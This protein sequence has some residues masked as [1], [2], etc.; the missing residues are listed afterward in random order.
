MAVPSV[1]LLP[2]CAAYGPRLTDALERAFAG[3]HDYAVSPKV[4]SVHT[5]WMELH[6]DLLQLQGIA[7]EE[8]GSY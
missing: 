7:R 5:V 3:D 4:D 8:E 1:G 2:R 6:E